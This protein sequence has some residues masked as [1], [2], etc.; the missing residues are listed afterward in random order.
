MQLPDAHLAFE[1]LIAF[2]CLDV[3]AHNFTVEQSQFSIAEN[4]LFAEMIA[5]SM[6]QRDIQVA[7]TLP[8]P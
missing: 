7:A 3:K 4:A 6:Q 1:N 5:Q 8:A 2:V